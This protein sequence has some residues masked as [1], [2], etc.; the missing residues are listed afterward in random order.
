MAV[1]TKLSRNSISL[2][3]VGMKFYCF[4]ARVHCC[5]VLYFIFSVNPM[6]RSEELR[7]ARDRFFITE[8]KEDSQK[9]L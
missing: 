3:L 1:V 2:G 6:R 7:E 9:K 8:S 4:K 5:Y